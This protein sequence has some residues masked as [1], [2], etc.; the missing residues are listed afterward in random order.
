MRVSRGPG[1]AVF[2]TLPI[3]LAALAAACGSTSTTRTDDRAPT[4]ALAATAPDGRPLLAVA[5]P[6]LSR[7]DE[8]GRTQVRERYESLTQT[9]TR[10]D[11][12]VAAVGRAYGEMG[13]LFMAAEYLDAAEPCLLNAHTLVPGDVRWPYYLGHLYRQRSELEKSAAFFEKALAIRPDDVLTL[14]WLGSVYLDQ[15]RPEEA[16]SRFARALLLQ[17]QS[18]AALYGA[19][20][21]ALARRDYAG[22]VA[23][24]EQALALDPKGTVVHY[25]L[26]LAYRGVGDVNTADAHLRLRGDVKVDP[27]DPLMDDLGSLLQTAQAFQSRAFRALGQGAWEE[28]AAYFSKA[29]ELA[30]QNGSLRLSLGTALLRSGDA[31]GALRQ[32]EEAVRLSPELANAHFSLGLL[33]EMSGRDLEAIERFATAVTVDPNLLTAHLRLAEALRRNGRV[34]E[35]LS[36][37]E[38]VTGVDPGVADARFG[39]AIA[40]VRLGRY[41]QARDELMG[42]MKAARGERRFA[43]ATARLLAAAPDGRV[44][45][46]RMALSIVTE[47][48]ESRPTIELAETHAMALAELG[49]YADAV[50]WQREA[51]AAARQAGS[52]AWLIRRLETNLARYERGEPCRMP[53]TDDDPIHAPGPQVEPELFEAA[54]TAP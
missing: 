26:A 54:A 43:H 29:A 7:M 47:L 37:Y 45:D 5:L 36:H 17:P 2:W 49:R 4:S 3:V 6:D 35:S 44:R 8:A 34:E 21:V 18:V 52:G 12:D 30:P 11:Q 39:H 48:L 24:L 14:L 32:Y 41:A 27:P 10:R 42:A 40:L 53:W 15:D 25:P 16:E 38:R 50:G 9:V 22:A 19:G 20:R 13:S 23:R 51:L 28:A 31:Q 33:L 46:G 1:A